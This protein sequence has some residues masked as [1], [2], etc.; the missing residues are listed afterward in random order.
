M[1]AD[2]GEREPRSAKPI[3]SE[4][5]TLIPWVEARTRL[6]EGRFYWLA[7]V[8]PDG[9]PHVRPILA[10]WHDGA[11]FTTTN[12][13][14]R[15][16]RNLAHDSRCAISVRTDGLD[17]VVE[18]SAAKVTDEATLERIAD[19]YKAKYEWPVT[20]RDGAF[21]APYGAPTAGP[22]PYEVYAVAPAVIFGFGTDEAYAPRTT[23]WEF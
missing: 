22:P 21:D 7:T 2:S 1:T 8:R 3:A 18:G 11:L 14:V 15:K 6:S 16:A 4:P 5:S 23:R 17:V 10:V 9:M 20:V 19:A 13:T 12:P